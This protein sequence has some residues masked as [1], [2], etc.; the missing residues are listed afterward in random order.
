MPILKI[1][2]KTLLSTLWSSGLCLAATLD[3]VIFPPV[4]SQAVPL[5]VGMSYAEARRLLIE[6]GWQPY[7]PTGAKMLACGKRGACTYEGLD[8]T[9]RERDSFF[10]TE[11]ALRKV[12]RQQG[13]Y[14]TVQCLPTGPGW[15]LHSFSDINGR[16]LVVRTG[17]GGYAEMPKVD[18]FYFSKE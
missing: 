2:M 1:P 14:E 4:W 10:R 6:N 5:K 9:E 11:L 8:Q 18:L 15:C 7:M 16:E 12:F 17:S 3:V 13:W